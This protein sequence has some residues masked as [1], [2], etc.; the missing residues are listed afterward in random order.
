[1]H[2]NDRGDRGIILDAVHGRP[3]PYPIRTFQDE[4][5]AYLYFLAR[6]RNTFHEFEKTSTE[7]ELWDMKANLLAIIHSFSTPST[8]PVMEREAFLAMM[9]SLFD[10]LCPDKQIPQHKMGASVPA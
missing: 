7:E 2:R 5:K 4:Q 1:M 3:L 8:S 9:D 10:Q 6:Y